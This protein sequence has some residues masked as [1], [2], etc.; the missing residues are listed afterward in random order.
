LP[1]SFV[2][3]SASFAE[4]ALEITAN[5]GNR[6]GGRTGKKMIKRF[7]LNRVDMFS[8]QFSV[9]VGVEGALSILP[10]P[11]D[12]VSPIRNAA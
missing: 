6:K 8:N 3:E 7:L 9:G 12:A 10:D 2:W 11:A 5:R 1:A 4:A